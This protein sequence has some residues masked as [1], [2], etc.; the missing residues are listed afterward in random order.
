MYSPAYR[1]N[2]A[3]D[4]RAAR[5]IRWLL[6]ACLL[7]PLL[8]SCATTAQRIART[9]HATPACLTISRK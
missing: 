5:L 8:S 7:A 4:A 1:P 2:L 9:A 3:A 6:C